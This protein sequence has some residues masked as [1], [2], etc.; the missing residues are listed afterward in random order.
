MK[1]KE[2]MSTSITCARPDTPISILAKQMKQENVGILPVCTDSGH[3]LGIVTDRDIVIRCLGKPQGMDFKTKDIMT[4]NV[5][6]VS[7]NMN[8]H[9]A[10]LLMSKHQIRRLPVVENN[11]LVGMLAI[12]DIARKRI[13]VDEAGDVISAVS[14]INGFQ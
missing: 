10:S 2:L 6:T 13:F 3:I 11:R 14:K 4:Q 8:T 12:A 7:P 9:D 5:I 1:V